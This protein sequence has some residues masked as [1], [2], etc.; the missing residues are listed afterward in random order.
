[1]GAVKV[2]SQRWRK[3]VAG[4]VV[5]AGVVGFAYWYSCT[6]VTECMSIV[7][8]VPLMGIGAAV[9]AVGMLLVTPI[10]RGRRLSRPARE[11]EGDGAAGGLRPG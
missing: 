7:G 1:M 9:G 5:G 11:R 6:H 8:A 2:P 4:G 3:A 10:E